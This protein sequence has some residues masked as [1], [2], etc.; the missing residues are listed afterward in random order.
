MKRVY[1]DSTTCNIHIRVILLWKR[2]RGSPISL[3]LHLSLLPLPS[4]T[5]QNETSCLFA[6]QLEESLGTTTNSDGPGAGQEI[7]SLVKIN[8]AGTISGF[9]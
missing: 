9:G 8:A 3:S 6:E 1:K 4:S 2:T 7:S 5:A